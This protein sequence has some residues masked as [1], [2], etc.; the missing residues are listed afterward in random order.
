M[1]SSR[2]VAEPKFRAIAKLSVATAVAWALSQTLAS[3]AT[4]S[5]DAAAGQTPVRSSP[6][7]AKE[8]IAFDI[9]ALPMSEALTRLGEQSG[10]TIIVETQVSKGIR[11]A[12]LSGRYT[13]DEALKKLLEPAG[14][15]AEY[16]DSRTVTVRVATV[17]GSGTAPRDRD[18]TQAERNSSYV[19]TA[20]AT[21]E[22][23]ELRKSESN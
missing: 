9:R 19:R 1:H 16:L 23:P 4:P 14:L 20:Q 18:T 7:E 15:K 5:V 12:A 6:G 8:T 2:R 17:A 11:S 21:A 10:L 22:S 3:A 13:A